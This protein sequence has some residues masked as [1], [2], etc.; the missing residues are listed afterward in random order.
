MTWQSLSIKR[1]PFGGKPVPLSFLSTGLPSG[2]ARIKPH[3]R[4][5]IPKSPSLRRNSPPV[6]LIQGSSGKHSRSWKANLLLPTCQSLW[7][8][9]ILLLLIRLLN[10]HFVNSAKAFT[11]P[12]PVTALCV[13]PP[14]LSSNTGF[15]F[16]YL[17]I[18]EVQDELTRLVPNKSAGFDGLDPTF[19]KASAHIIAAPITRIFNLSLQLSVFPLV[20]KL[21]MIFPSFKGGSGSNGNCY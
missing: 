15:Y 9:T 19:L 17:S 14:S 11:I 12:D 2:N 7:H 3:R 18:S 21:A 8:S 13:I 6:A 5:R 20:W 10:N 1:T 4:S 16:K